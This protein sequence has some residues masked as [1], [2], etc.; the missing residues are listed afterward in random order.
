[1]AW[2]CATGMKRE[3]RQG[4]KTG[5]ENRVSENRGSEHRLKQDMKTGCENRGPKERQHMAGQGGMKRACNGYE[6]GMKQTG[7]GQ[8]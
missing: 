4:M 2:P 5:C 6:T 1:M 7:M 3:W 8:A